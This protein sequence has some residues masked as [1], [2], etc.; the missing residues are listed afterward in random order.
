MRDSKDDQER[1]DTYSFLRETLELSRHLM[2]RCL[3]RYNVLL[4]NLFIE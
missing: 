4:W 3:D 2:G 1:L